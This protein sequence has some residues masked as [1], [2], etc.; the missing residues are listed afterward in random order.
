[1]KRNSLANV[2]FGHDATLQIKTAL[3]R[4]TTLKITIEKAFC[5]FSNHKIR[6]H[7][8]RQHQKNCSGGTTKPRCPAKGRM[9]ASDTTISELATSA[10]CG[11][12]LNGLPRV[13]MIKITSTW[14]MTDSINQPVAGIISLAD[15]RMTSPGTSVVI[16]IS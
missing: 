12:L 15:S 5:Q 10:L 1:M 14:A 2:V 8:S 7:H 13:R 9:T 4:L 6:N 3:V 16:G 11:L